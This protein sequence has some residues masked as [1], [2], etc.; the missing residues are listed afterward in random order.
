MQP[1]A[2]SRQLNR[3]PLFAFRQTLKSCHPER[4][5]ARGF[6]DR[7]RRTPIALGNLRSSALF[8]GYNQFFPEERA[9]P[10]PK[11]I[12]SPNCSRPRRPSPSSASP[13]LLYGRATASRTTCS[14]RDI[15]SFPVNPNI[16]DWMGEKAYASLLDVPEKIDIVNVFRRSGGRP[17]SRRAGH[18]DQSSGHLDAGRRHS[19][20]GR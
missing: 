15:A 16:T 2:I 7:S 13:I 10:Q 18:P 11:P 9:W 5:F 4:R 20:R 19:R 1:S 8:A 17:R 12:A 3:R 6:A 14:R